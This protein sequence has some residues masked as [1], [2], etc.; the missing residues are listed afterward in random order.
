MLLSLSLRARLVA[1]LA[2]A[3]LLAT[4]VAGA[5]SSPQ[6]DP[7]LSVVETESLVR[8]RYYEGLPRDEAERIGPAGCARLLE[9]LD[10]PA[11]ARVHDQVMVAIG[12]CAPDGALEAIDAWVAALPEGEI[13]RARF[14]GWMAVSRALSALSEQDP[15]AVE[16]LESR[17]SSAEAPRFRHGRHRGPRLVRLRR[18]GSTLGLA[19]TGLPQAGEALQRADLRASDPE[20]VSLLR[21]ARARHGDRADERRQRRRER[22]GRR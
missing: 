7:E 13:D 2:C 16:R 10:D 9:M 12:I 6:D 15:R 20:F 1:A 19:E 17:M 3:S 18:T 5:Q 14:K 4:G 11:E 22:G 8:A 21:R